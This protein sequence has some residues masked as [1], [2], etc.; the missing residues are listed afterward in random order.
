[1]LPVQYVNKK[2]IWKYIIQYLTDTQLITSPSEFNYLS[3]TT[4]RASLST[5]TMN[6]QHAALNPA[7]QG[8]SKITLL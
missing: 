8:T 6:D 7:Q 1:M 2:E 5:F 3:S 4:Q